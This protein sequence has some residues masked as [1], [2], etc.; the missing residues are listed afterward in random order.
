MATAL[1]DFLSARVIRGLT[2]ARLNG[3]RQLT[4]EAN[5]HTLFPEKHKS[6]EYTRDIVELVR[7]PA[8]ISVDGRLCARMTL[9][10]EADTLDAFGASINKFAHIEDG[11]ALPYFLS[12]QLGFV[13]RLNFTGIVKPGAWVSYEA[14]REQWEALDDATRFMLIKCCKP[15]RNLLVSERLTLCFFVP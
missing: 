7:F 14:S 5:V 1:E 10:Q 8:L 2:K 12:N 4:Y 9:E 3:P 13:V 6:S 15:P 11:R